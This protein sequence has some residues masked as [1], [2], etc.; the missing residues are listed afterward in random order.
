MAK[1]SKQALFPFAKYTDRYYK[2]IEVKILL[3]CLTNRVANCIQDYNWNNHSIL[4]NDFFKSNL[5]T[6]SII[7]GMPRELESELILEDRYMGGHCSERYDWYHV[8]FI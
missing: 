1:Q 4:T 7:V 5:P 6:S 8:H 3:L 2:L